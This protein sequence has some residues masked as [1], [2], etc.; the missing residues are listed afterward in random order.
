MKRVRMSFAAS[1]DYAPT[2][3]ERTARRSV[4]WDVE[5]GTWSNR[6]AM[7]RSIRMQEK[8]APRQ[9]DWK[10]VVALGVTEGH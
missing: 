9:D 4:G 6:E 1:L 2:N 7:A 8:R 5:F 3:P 10:A